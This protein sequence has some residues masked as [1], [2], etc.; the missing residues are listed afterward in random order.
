MYIRVFPCNTSNNACT[1]VC[2]V[3][4]Y[5]STAKNGVSAYISL[6]FVENGVSQGVWCGVW[7]VYI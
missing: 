1:A 2:I 3:R 6:Y 4:V 5:I 7:R